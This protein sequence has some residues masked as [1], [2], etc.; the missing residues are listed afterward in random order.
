MPPAEL[1]HVSP[2]S[3]G[4]ACRTCTRAQEFNLSTMLQLDFQ[5]IHYMIR[6]HTH[7]HQERDEPDEHVDKNLF[8]T[9][10]YVFL[11]VSVL[12]L[13]SLLF[14]QMSGLRLTVPRTALL[15]VLLTVL[16]TALLTVCSLSIH[17]LFTASEHLEETTTQ[18]M[19]PILVHSLLRYSSSIQPRF[20][21]YSSS[22]HPLFFLYASSIHPLFICDSYSLLV[23]SGS[24]VSPLLLYCPSTLFGA[25]A[26]PIHCSLPMYCLFTAYLLQVT[27]SLGIGVPGNDS[28]RIHWYHPIHPII[29]HQSSSINPLFTDTHCHI[30]RTFILDSTIHP[31]FILYPSSH[32][33]IHR[34][35]SSVHPLFSCFLGDTHPPFTLYS[36]SIHPLFIL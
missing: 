4:T 25:H 11:V 34:Y 20:I 17:C 7:T 24:S 12:V 21:L 31:L 1:E 35:P 3:I 18:D 5:C 27:A 10:T 6:L 32:P 23:T 8:A 33:S 30:T 13:I 36:T 2:V 26:L 9:S 28:A 29:N 22:I 14:A 15:T 16:S 19:K